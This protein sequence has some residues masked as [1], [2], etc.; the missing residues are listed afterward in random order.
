MRF[1]ERPRR[2]GEGEHQRVY[3]PQGRATTAAEQAAA[4]AA[5][6]E[7]SSFE[8]SCSRG[9]AERVGGFSPP[10]VACV[11]FFVE[12]LLAAKQPAASTGLLHSQRRAQACCILSDGLRSR[13]SQQVLFPGPFRRS[14]EASIEPEQLVC[15][16][17]SPLVRVR[18]Y[19]ATRV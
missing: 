16:F 5:P 11:S 6:S 17:I 18:Y 13:V 15:L 14:P 1:H 8:R 3:R 2:K 9:P 19:A 10:V 4:A 12:G 7:F